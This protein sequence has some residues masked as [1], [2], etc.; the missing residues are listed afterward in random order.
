MLVAF[1][2]RRPLANAFAKGAW[3]EREIHGPPRLPP[4]VPASGHS[5]D[6][7]RGFGARSSADLPRQGGDRPDANQ[8]LGQSALGGEAPDRFRARIGRRRGD[9]EQKRSRG[10]SHKEERPSRPSQASARRTTRKQG[11]ELMNKQE[12]SGRFAD[13]S[14]QTGREFIERGISGAEEKK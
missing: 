10:K 8:P 11:D 9:R 5:A 2:D 6:N 12:H 14:T 1:R 13:K 4:D 3:Q 7:G